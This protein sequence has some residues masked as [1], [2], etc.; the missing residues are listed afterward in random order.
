MTQFFPNAG[1]VSLFSYS[2][3]SVSWKSIALDKSIYSVIHSG[4]VFR[5]MC[6]ALC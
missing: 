1:I 3:M 5:S 4:N 2:R 6:Q